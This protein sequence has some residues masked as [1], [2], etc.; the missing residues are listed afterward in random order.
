MKILIIEDE[1]NLRNSLCELLKFN[2]YE[3][4]VA[5]H[6]LEALSLMSAGEH[7]DLVISDIIMPE[8]DGISLFKTMQADENLKFIPFI[9]L[10]ARAEMD[11][12][13]LGMSLGADDY[14]TKPVKYADLIAAVELR[15]QKKKS[16]VDD[17]SN[18]LLS[19]NN[20]DNKRRKEDLA[21]MLQPISAS[22]M[23]VLSALA[24]FKISKIIAENLFL[25]V[26]TVQN[27]R[28][29]MAIKLG[30]SGQNSLLVFAVECKACGLL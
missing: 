30:M 12:I 4:I 28:A 27:H 24:E 23:R 7:P 20:A 25:S 19:T 10:T 16:L 18:R 21:L 22:E 17:I 29:H 14:I 2:M 8:M 9:F 26:K 5:E 13:R 3:V 1:K 11:D 15:L 6:G